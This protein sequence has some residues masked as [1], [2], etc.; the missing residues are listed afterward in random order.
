MSAAQ[1]WLALAVAFAVPVLQIAGILEAPHAT[2]WPAY[3]AISV[4]ALLSATRARDAERLY[5]LTAGAAI[6][7]AIAFSMVR[8]F[9]PDSGWRSWTGGLGSPVNSHPV[10]TDVVMLTLATFGVYAL[11]WGIGTALSAIRNDRYLTQTRMRLQEQETHLRIQSDRERIGRE[12]HDT[13][14]HSLAIIVSQSQGAEA[15]ASSRPEAVLP[16]L[17][18]IAQVSRES[19]FEVRQLIES[20]QDDDVLMA[21]PGLSDIPLLLDRM[22]GAGLQVE[23]SIR[24]KPEHVSSS[25]ELAVYR[26]L[27][28][29][30]TNALK[31]SDRAKVVHVVEI[32]TPS[33]LRLEVI[34]S[35]RRRVDT[36]GMVSGGVGVG[37]MRERA[38]LVGGELTVR[39]EGERFFVGA[40]LPIS[41]TASPSGVPGE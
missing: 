9:S 23:L 40:T 20:I 22:R 13:L 14:A 12:V 8:P 39:G 15:I 18:A 17:S 33:T 37:S 29:A 26:I 28:E 27:Q 10:R 3:G 36:Y 30:L 25:T 38:R 31:H 34:S 11:S 41:L 35:G 1:P 2:T 21:K 7:A 5:N 19:L 32:W 4:V 6:S 16:A 24:G